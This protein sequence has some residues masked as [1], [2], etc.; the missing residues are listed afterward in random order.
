MSHDSAKDRDQ[1]QKYFT[2]SP[3]LIHDKTWQN[4]VSSSGFNI[5]LFDPIEQSKRHNLD[6]KEDRDIAS[7]EEDLTQ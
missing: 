1:N 5:F 7:H 2:A 6:K 3:N 4:V